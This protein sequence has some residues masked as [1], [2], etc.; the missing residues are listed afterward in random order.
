MRALILTMSLLLINVT[1]KT[2]VLAYQANKVDAQ[3]LLEPKL[4]EE[5]QKGNALLEQLQQNEQV[6]AL[7]KVRKGEF[8]KTALAEIGDVKDELNNF[9]SKDDKVVNKA[10]LIAFVKKEKYK[11]PL[12]KE[13]LQKPLISKLNALKEEQVSIGSLANLL[14]DILKRIEKKDLR[15]HYKAFKKVYKYDE[16]KTSEEELEEIYVEDVTTDIGFLSRLLNYA[17]KLHKEVD[18]AEKE[19]ER[20]RKEAEKAA[21]EAY[22]R[23][24]KEFGESLR[25][26]IHN[27]SSYSKMGYKDAEDLMVVDII[28]LENNI[29]KVITTEYTASFAKEIQFL[30]MN[31][32][33]SKKLLVPLGDAKDIVEGLLTKVGMK[34]TVIKQMYKIY[35]KEKG[36]VAAPS[37]FADWM[38]SA[39]YKAD[40]NSFEQEYDT[41]IEKVD[42]CIQEE[43]NKL[44]SDN[45]VFSLRPKLF[46]ENI[47]AIFDFSMDTIQSQ[48]GMYI[49]EHLAKALSAELGNVK[50]SMAKIDSIWQAVLN[51]AKRKEFKK[52]LYK[53][54]F[55]SKS[56]NLNRVEDAVALVDSLF[57][58]PS[59]VVGALYDSR[60]IPTPLPKPKSDNK[61]MIEYELIKGGRD[62]KIDL[63]FGL[64]LRFV[65]E[66]DKDGKEVYLPLPA[67]TKDLKRVSATSYAVK[68]KKVIVGEPAIS[69]DNRLEAITP[70]TWHLEVTDT[71]SETVIQEKMAAI[72]D[73]LNINVGDVVTG[74]KLKEVLGED[75]ALGEDLLEAGIKFVGTD[76][77]NLKEIVGE[78]TIL[79]FTFEVGWG[80]D[81]GVARFKN[82]LAAIEEKRQFTYGSSSFSLYLSCDVKSDM[83]YGKNS[84]CDVSA[85]NGREGNAKGGLK[86]DQIK[87]EESNGTPLSFPVIVENTDK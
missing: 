32:I 44:R 30:C 6:A 23:F 2:P 58:Q 21:K 36:V 29:S 78:I 12:G 38:N 1:S 45:K 55:I 34:E 5:V 77:G 27:L 86:S 63:L 19:A 75:T 50:I 69:R 49:Y 87:L 20:K 14:N 11:T 53:R 10:A 25:D 43:E 62:Q 60:Y 3:E 56:V 67:S 37:G 31:E 47:K 22:K 39:K 74:G 83:K 85:Y 42:T 15:Q 24:K 59:A 84:Y 64:P 18:D 73:Y 70:V 76:N 81:G 79:G 8:I 9:A 35:K 82:P 17:F 68:L 41:W 33:K 4:W 40:F 72:Y 26:I 51:D 61:L 80:Q 7:F 13:V 66:T 28:E 54:Y 52:T 16:D 57:S 71:S 46:D 48:P 65:V